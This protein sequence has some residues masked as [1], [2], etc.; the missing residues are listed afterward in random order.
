VSATSFVKATRQP[1]ERGSIH[2]HTHAVAPGDILESPALGLRAEV[3]ESD[4]DLFRADVHARRGGNG[5]PLHRHLRQEERFLV[6]EGRLRVREGFRGARLV[7]AGEEVAI[8]AGKPHTFSVVSDGA[9]FTAEFRPAWEI[10]EVFRDVFALSAE[11]RLDRRG[12][13]RPR[14]VARLIGRY[15]DDFFYSAL[16]PVAVQRA[17]ALPLLRRQAR[18]LSKQP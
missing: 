13:P 6:H 3:L 7:E 18:E 10:A 2:E 9:H 17:L 11:G 8:R 5:G 15:P 12:N 14:D 16:L 4:R 1:K